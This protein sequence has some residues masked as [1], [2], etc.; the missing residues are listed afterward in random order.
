MRCASYCTA[1]RY[2][3]DELAKFLRDKGDDPK[4]YDYVI[5]I[6]Q[7]PADAIKEIFYFPYGCVIF[8]GFSEGE[9]LKIL[10]ELKAFEI[11]AIEN[12]TA[13]HCIFEVGDE[14]VI[15]EE[16]DLIVLESDDALIKLSFSHAL[17]QSVKLQVFETAIERTIEKT[18]HIPA[19]LAQKGKISMS[20]KKLA[21]Q[22]GV[23]FEQRNS[24][25]L[26]CDILDTPEFFWRRPKYEP[27]Y[28]MAA[29][30]MDI[31]TRLDIMNRRL[32]VIHE[33]YDI[34][35]NELKHAHSSYLE[36]TIILLI[37][38][39]V[40]MHILKDLLKWI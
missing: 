18:R 32:D 40:V 33:L 7:G 37:V 34:L 8:W 36:M 9:E 27:I 19:E 14:T 20:R 23:L 17:T 22:M 31:A 15:H 13:D 30:Y 6:H 26:H 1:D 24:M 2:N 29:Q 21:Q 11:D 28:H 25:N 12:I 35:S 10:Q 16:D 3:V 5:H 38:T 4:H 39:E